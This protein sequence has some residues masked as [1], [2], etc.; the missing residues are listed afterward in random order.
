MCDWTV[1]LNGVL[2]ARREYSVVLDRELSNRFPR[3]RLPPKL[4]EF[5]VASGFAAR[6]LR[7]PP[8]LTG[9]A[10]R[11][12]A[13]SKPGEGFEPEGDSL[14]SSPRARIPTRLYVLA[15]ARTVEPGRGFEPPNSRLQVGCLVRPS[16]PGTPGR[17][18]SSVV[19]LSL[20]SA[21]SSS[22]RWG[23]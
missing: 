6:T 2:N 10:S 12:L 17:Y 18:R 19:R 23:S 13:P 5:A 3:A 22:T 4:L 14:H 11:S 21:F 8:V 15:V 16:S 20:S 9:R 7:G 1:V